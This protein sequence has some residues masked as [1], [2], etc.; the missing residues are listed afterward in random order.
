MLKKRM[1]NLSFKVIFIISLIFLLSACVSFSKIQPQVDNMVLVNNYERALEVL[2][3]NSNT[4]GKNNQLLFLLD[5]GYIQHLAGRYKESIETFDKAKLKFDELYTKSISK[6]AATWIINDYSAPYHGEDFESVL[7][8]IFQALNYA[9]LGNYA[10][11]LVE[12][13]EVDSKLNAI[14]GQYQDNQK[15][16]YKEDAF[17]RFLMGIF[18][19]AGNTKA[20]LNDAFISYEKA[21]KIYN[22]DYKN[23]YDLGAPNIL[24][25]N[26]LTT[27]R[28]MGFS[29]F[30]KYREKFKDFKFV[31]LEDKKN[32]AEVYLIQYNGLAPVKIEESVLVPMPDGHIIKIAFPKYRSRI[33]GINTSRL[34]AKNVKGEVFQADTEL[35]ENIGAIAIKNLENRK[36]RFIAKT[37]ARST[38]RYLIE[39]KQEKGIKKKFGKVSEEWFRFFSNIYNLI[40]EQADLR[41]WQTLPDQIRISRLILLP[42]E[43][44]VSVENFSSNGSHL[45]EFKLEK[46]T[47]NADQKKFFL[48]HASR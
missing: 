17:A 19:E 33:Y 15:N 35:G 18:Y 47:L 4:Y 11:A 8:N 34:L 45:G 2:K 37:I 48:L 12:A 29:E 23:N 36:C 3:D 13:R 20:D 32:T 10:D 24:K 1:S 40:I 5:K 43:Y 14:N 21:E 42:G 30:G 39:K 44:E 38:G 28:F 9:M 26:L 22:N 6:I 41:C 46:V 16:V 31:S 25:E 27:S 7:I